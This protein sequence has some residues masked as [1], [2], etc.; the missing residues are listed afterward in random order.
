MVATLTNEGHGESSEGKMLEGGFMVQIKQQQPLE[1]ILSVA[2]LGTLAE[3]KKDVDAHKN[4]NVVH[5]KSRGHPML[6]A[7]LLFSHNVPAKKT[8]AWQFQNF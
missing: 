7:R 6:I 4:L 2:N 5:N 1:L 8:P 3:T